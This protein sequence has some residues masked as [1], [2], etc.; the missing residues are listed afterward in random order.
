MKIIASLIV[1]LF[2]STFIATPQQATLQFVHCS[3]DSALNTV[4]IWVDT[5]KVFDD[6][7]FR[8]SSSPILMDTGLSMEISIC[9]SNSNDTS[10]SL[11]KDSIILTN[12]SRYQ[13]FLAGNITQGYTPF[14]DLQ[15]SLN[16][17][18]STPSLI[19]HS[20]FAFYNGASDLDS[21]DI[22]DITASITQLVA[23]LKFSQLSHYNE[24]EA[25]NYV[26]R[27]QK[28]GN[29]DVIRELKFFLGDQQLMDS[30]FTVAITGFDNRSANYNG[31][32]L[33]FHIVRN[34]GGLFIPL[35]NALTQ[36]Q[37]IN[38]VPEKS[39]GS[40]DFY[41]NG[42][43]SADNLKFRSST[44][45]INV[46]SGR[47]MELSAA[48][49][50]SSNSNDSIVR[51]ESQLEYGKEYT[52]ILNGLQDS[53]ISPYRPLT[54][55]E[56]RSKKTASTG[57]NCDIS[58]VHGA[59][60]L[61]E[62]SVNETSQLG[63]SLFSQ[64]TFGNFEEYQSIPAAN[65]QIEIKNEL[66]DQVLLSYSVP[67]SQIGGSAQTWILSGFSDTNSSDSTNRL[68]VYV[69]TQLGGQLAELNTPTGIKP[70]NKNGITIFPNPTNGI[71]RLREV[72]ESIDYSIYGLD[73]KL[74]LKGSTHKDFSIN[75]DSLQSG[76]Y[77]MLLESGDY[78]QTERLIL[79]Q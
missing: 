48:N 75:L 69:A 72:F 2:A 46:A 35:D 38:N 49:S 79:S 70:A 9:A 45:Y 7:N 16:E 6:F 18:E 22:S 25:F 27:I 23:D 36:I 15:L 39:L 24:I 71:I 53:N 57:Y 33:G 66:S 4:D 5:T 62:I 32:A 61:D 43:L 34:Y 37:I 55:T 12:S 54:F 29:T 10:N 21:I 67:F 73:G 17:A 26:F 47:A 19:E 52:F 14:Y 42:N 68:G 31:P 78:I 60:D 50:S 58:W 59:T 13:V 65:Y 64:S 40:L 11:F 44:G 1:V 30:A 51:I 3:A 20:A 63:R 76:I 74:W 77:F 28:G 41:I 56:F 8:T